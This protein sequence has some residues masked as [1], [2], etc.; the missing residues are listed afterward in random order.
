[1]TPI[2]YDFGGLPAYWKKPNFPKLVTPSGERVIYEL[3]KFFMTATPISH[4]EFERLEKATRSRK[5]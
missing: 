5:S 2:F 1:M 3:V 4:E